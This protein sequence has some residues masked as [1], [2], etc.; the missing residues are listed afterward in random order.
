MPGDKQSHPNHATRQSQPLNAFLRVCR[1]I[2]DDLYDRQ[3]TNSRLKTESAFVVIASIKHC[4]QGVKV[5]KIDMSI[6]ITDFSVNRLLAQFDI[7]CTW[8]FLDASV[9]KS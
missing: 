2:S 3:H 8:I 7:L 5:G 1:H 6:L 9:S 4:F